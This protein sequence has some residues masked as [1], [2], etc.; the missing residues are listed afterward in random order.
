MSYWINNQVSTTLSCAM[1]VEAE[2][3]DLR[4]P[5]ETRRLQTLNTKRV[6][7]TNLLNLLFKLERKSRTYSI[8]RM[9]WV[10]P[11]CRKWVT[12]C[13]STD[14]KKRLASWRKRLTS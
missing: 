11:I 12:K 10:I 14:L 8:T 7:E 2:K 13:K 4:D 3:R 1:R 9:C 6:K 5:A